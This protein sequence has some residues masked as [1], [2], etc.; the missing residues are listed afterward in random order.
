VYDL[1][2]QPRQTRRRP[3]CPVIDILVGQSIV[4]F[5]IATPGLKS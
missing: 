4:S 5:W 2:L 1:N 3:Y